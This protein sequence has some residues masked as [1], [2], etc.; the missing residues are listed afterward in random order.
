MEIHENYSN[1]PKKQRNCEESRS[2]DLVFPE[3]GR[4]PNFNMDLQKDDTEWNSFL[5]SHAAR[6]IL[7]P[8]STRFRRLNQSV[9]MM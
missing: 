5:L 8:T 3:F 1:S 6:E 9:C 2:D 7:L 4:P